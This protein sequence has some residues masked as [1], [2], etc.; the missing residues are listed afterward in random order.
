MYMIGLISAIKEN[1]RK[2]MQE[3]SR[4]CQR[5]Q[6]MGRSKGQG[7]IIANPAWVKSDQD[8]LHPFRGPGA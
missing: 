4:P 3:F 1:G 2:E 6:S 5:E 8:I 7:D